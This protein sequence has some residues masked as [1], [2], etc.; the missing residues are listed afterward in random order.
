MLHINPN[1]VCAIIEK[2]Q[3]FHAKEEV[4]IPHDN[5]WDGDD[6]WAMQVLA[7]H[8]DDDTLQELKYIIQDLDPSH[9]VELVALIWLGRG[10]Y[11]TEEWHDA[12]RE[13]YNRWNSRV[14]DYVISSPQVAD[15]LQE[16]LWALGY[17]CGEE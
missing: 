2:C 9:Q 4:S 14:A 6:D 12:V 13:A 7:D 17:G 11:T 3:G 8:S 15:Y 10:D 5:D 1:V 16:G